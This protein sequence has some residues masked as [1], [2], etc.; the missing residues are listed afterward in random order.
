MTNREKYTTEILDIA[1]NGDSIAMTMDDELVG[2]REINCDECKFCW[3]SE[4]G[5]CKEN[6]RKWANSGYIEKI[7]ISESDRRF[8]DYLSDACK[9]IVR[10]KDGSLYAYRSKPTK[11][12]VGYWK[13]ETP[14]TYLSSGLKIDFDM[15]KWSD[16]MP[17]S[18]EDLK[19]LEVR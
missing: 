9:W 2:C 14:S 1:C 18:I 10:D 4:S 5:N 19:M 17:W 7:T 16:D 13:C 8:L 12:T 3:S 6:S 15:I 11:E